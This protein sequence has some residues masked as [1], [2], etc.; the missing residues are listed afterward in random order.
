MNIWLSSD[1]HLF[2][3]NIIKYCNRP[4]EDADKMNDDIVKRWNSL[5]GK[6][7]VCVVVG[8]VSAGLK[9]RTHEYSLLLKSMNGSKILIRGN[10]D[11]EPDDFYLNSGFVHVVEHMFVA[12]V[13]FCHHPP[14]DDRDEPQGKHNVS[15]CNEYISRYDP[16]AI[17]HG[18]DHR[19]EVSDRNKCFNCAVER[20]NYTPVL[21]AEALRRVDSS[22]AERYHDHVT[23]A[24]LS[25]VGV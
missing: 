4:Y 20:H 24:I 12:G 2:H 15:R 23:R 17:V 21:L 5:V 22:S 1:L 11:H 7:D 3:D 8:D 25:I 16:W 18:H 13:L 6:D 14:T 9:G 19:V 10:H